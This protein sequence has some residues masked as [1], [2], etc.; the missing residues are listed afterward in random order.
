M[1][2]ELQRWGTRITVGCHSVT[3]AKVFVKLISRLLNLLVRVWTRGIITWRSPVKA[4]CSNRCGR[5]GLRHIT[6]LGHIAD[7]ETLADH[8]AEADVFLHANP[9]EPIGIAPLE[10]RPWSHRKRAA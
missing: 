4:C 7:R 3:R 6:F 10:A 1:H 8:Y 9:R 2:I 5:R